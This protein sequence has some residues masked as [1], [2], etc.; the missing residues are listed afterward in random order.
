MQ[1]TWAWHMCNNQCVY[2]FD[3]L[4]NRQWAMALMVVWETGLYNLAEQCSTKS[5]SYAQISH[6]IYVMNMRYLFVVKI[7]SLLIFAYFQFIFVTTILYNTEITY[8]GRSYPTWLVH[9]GYTSC[10]SSIICIPI[11]ILYKLTKMNGS[12]K[13]VMRN[14]SPMTEAVVCLFHKQIPIDMLLKF[15]S[16]I[17][18]CLCVA[19]CA[20]IFRDYGLPLLLIIGVQL[21]RAIEEP[22][23]K[24]CVITTVTGATRREEWKRRK[25]H[26]WTRFKTI[27]IFLYKHILTFLL[28]W[29]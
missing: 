6:Y 17:R 13:K 10:A 27:E 26:N 8:G 24:C 29:L 5:C 23:R 1:H 15:N 25:I 19:L 11:Y 18:V 9:I 28:L 3:C 14:C 4:A 2:N 20:H 22:G 7:F 12:I 16:F 21:R